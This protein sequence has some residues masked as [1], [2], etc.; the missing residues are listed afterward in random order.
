MKNFKKLSKTE[1]KSVNAGEKK[2]YCFYC[3]WMDKVI[4]SEIHL[5]QC[6]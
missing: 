3:E 1:L 2:L 6:P 4:C 5:S